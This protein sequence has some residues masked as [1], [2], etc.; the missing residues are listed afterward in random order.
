VSYLAIAKAASMILI[1]S[2]AVGWLALIARRRLAMGRMAPLQSP[3]FFLN[4]FTGGLTIIRRCRWLIIVPL[5]AVG[6]Q[7]CES[8]FWASLYMQRNPADARRFTRGEPEQLFSFLKSLLRD[9]PEEFLRTAGQIDG[10]TLDAL[11]SPLILGAF[12]LVVM[13]IVLRPRHDGTS[14]NGLTERQ[15]R[16]VGALAGLGGLAFVVVPAAQNFFLMNQKYS[17]WIYFFGVLANLIALPFAYAL[18]IPAMDAAHEESPVSLP[19]GLS[20]MEWHFRPLFG[21]VLVSTLLVRIAILPSSVHL[22]VDPYHAFDIDG[23]WR[24]K[25]ALLCA[26]LAMISFIPVIAVVRRASFASAFNSCIE[27]WARHAKN[28]AVF[29]G[30]GA[31]L[32]LVPVT[33]QGKIFRLFSSYVGW[34]INTVQLILSLYKVAAGVLIMSSMVVFYKRTLEEPDEQTT[35]GMN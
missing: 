7:F 22:F 10:A 2:A 6:I 30:L 8:L 13:I 21:Y 12:M 25:E 28:A 23:L 29:L 16:W 32:L 31:L 15:R 4:T 3:R 9:I 35:K 27:L 33:L 14:D 20:T 1:G 18:L 34:K 11:R 17:S 24:L 26:L 5:A 19:G